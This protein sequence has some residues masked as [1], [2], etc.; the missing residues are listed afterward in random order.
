MFVEQANN[1]YVH[2][3]GDYVVK[4]S[5]HED[6]PCIDDRIERIW[7][8][9]WKYISRKKFDTHYTLLYEIIRYN[10]FTIKKIFY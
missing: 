4:I 7:G 1:L 5:F 2:R 8:V 9:L 3:I 10:I 6:S